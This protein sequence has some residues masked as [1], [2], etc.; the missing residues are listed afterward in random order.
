VPYPIIR[1]VG[2]IGSVVVIVLAI[3]CVWFWRSVRSSESVAL[4]LALDGYPVSIERLQHLAHELGGSPSLVTFYLQ[5]PSDPKAG[6]IPLESLKAIAQSGSVPVLTWEPM[7]ITADGERAIPSSDIQA[8]LYDDYIRRMAE[9]IESL[10]TVVWIRFAHEMN[11]Q[12]YHWGSS[13]KAFGPESPDRY[14]RMYRYVVSR[15]RAFGAKS[16]QF[17]FCPNSESVPNEVWNKL[18]NY[19]P[20]DDVVNLLG[21]DGYSWEA[22]GESG[23]RSFSEIFRKP[24]QELRYLSQSKPIWVF[25]SAAVGSNDAKLRWLEKALKTSANW[26]VE[27]IVWFHVKKENDWRLPPGTLR[28]RPMGIQEQ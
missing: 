9:G 12:R 2:T 28:K 14:K 1:L 13:E 17:I 6:E 5:W 23:F 26:G 8:G 10:Q 3:G 25:E 22:E 4:G 20:G 7:S 11:L 24:V 19:Y 15:M 18:S 21:I 16:S 27:G